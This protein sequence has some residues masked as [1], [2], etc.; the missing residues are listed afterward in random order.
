M[1]TTDAPPDGSPPIGI[2]GGSGLYELLSDAETGRADTPYGPPS[3][4]PL[5]GR[6]GSRAVAFLPRHGR[7][8]RFAPHL[9][10]YRANLWALRSLG[11]RQI[12]AVAAVGS[13]R[14]DLGVGSLVI[15][16]QVVDRTY[17]RPHTFY[18]RPGRVAHVPFADPYCPVGRR[19]VAQAAR[20]QG[21]EP[22]ESA[23]LVVVQGPR[24]SSRAESR[25]HAAQGWSIVNMTGQPEAGLARE[26]GL[27]YTTIAIVTDLDAGL[28]EGEGVT[29]A[30]VFQA[31]E[32]S[33]A[34]V[35]TLLATVVEE[36]PVEPGCSC[37][38][39]PPIPDSPPPPGPLS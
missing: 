12:F 38:D 28:G 14:S 34:R 24:F 39:V 20:A 9:V 4:P 2:I 33:I 30:D 17:G 8:H 11:V 16:D 37:A 7:D 36:A 31:F 22:V 3:E 19:V 18:D 1:T 23:T 25:F 32:R 13:L 10:P 35:R 26:L 27:C 5:I 21:W 6:L 15:P 29:E